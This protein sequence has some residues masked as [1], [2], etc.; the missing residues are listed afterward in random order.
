MAS[1]EREQPSMWPEARSSDIQRRAEYL[2]IIGASD[3]VLRCLPFEIGDLPSV[4]FIKGLALPV[5]SQT[6]QYL[7]LAEDALESG[8][9]LGVYQDIFL[10]FVYAKVQ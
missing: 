6:S 1:I 7:Q 9:L 8:F 2:K 10:G 4:P 5:V 3:Y